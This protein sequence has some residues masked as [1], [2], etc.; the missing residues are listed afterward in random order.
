MIRFL[1]QL[2]LCI[3]F[4]YTLLEFFEFSG[5]AR[6]F[7]GL[8]FSLMF[9]ALA[10]YAFPTKIVVDKEQ[11]KELIKKLEQMERDAKEEE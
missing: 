5:I 10:Y 7:A 1:V 8:G 6:L 4:N 2:F 3:C 9:F 11:I